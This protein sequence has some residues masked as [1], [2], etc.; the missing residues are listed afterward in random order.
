VSNPT[1]ISTGGVV[2]VSDQNT[3]IN[4]IVPVS[5]SWTLD[6]DTFY[7]YNS[8]SSPIPLTQGFSYF[9][10]NNF[11]QTS[12][13]PLTHLQ[14]THWTDGTWHIQDNSTDTSFPIKPYTLPV[15]SKVLGGVKS[16]GSN[17][18]IDPD[19]TINAVNGAQVQSDWNETN[20]ALPDFILN[21]PTFLQVQSDWNETNPALPDF[22]LNKPSIPSPYVLPAATPTV[23]GGI[24]VGSGLVITGDVL[25]APGG[26][27]GI[28][29]LTGDGTAGPGTGSQP[30][31]LASVVAPGTVGDTT[32]VAQVTIDG[33]GRVTA[34]TPIAIAGVSPTCMPKASEVGV[35]ANG[36]DQTANLIAALS[37]PNY[38]GIVFDFSPAS[39]VVINGSVNCN[40]K[41]LRFQPGNIITG[42]FTI[43]NF[44]LDCNIRQKCF[45]IGSSGVPVGITNPIGTTLGYISPWVFGA[46]D[47]GSDISRAW[48]ATIDLCIRNGNKVCHIK[49]P[50]GTYTS[51][52]PVIE[53]LW[54]GSFYA[55]HQVITDGETNFSEASSFGTVINFTR[56]DCFCHATQAS[57]GGSLKNIK[58]TGPFTNP[59][60][61]SSYAFYNTTS[62][63]YTDGVT[64]DTQFSPQAINVIDPF[65]PSIPADGGYPG[66]D[67]YGQPL[68]EYYRGST[69]GT[70]GYEYENVFRSGCVVGLVTSPNGQTA[71]AEL[72]SDRNA[73]FQNYKWMV[74]GCQTQEKGNLV[75][76]FQ[77]W[78]QGYGIFANNVYGSQAAGGWTF[79]DGNIA[80]PNVLFGSYNDSGFI[81]SFFQNIFIELLGSMGSMKTDQGASFTDCTFNFAPYQS[82]QS[83]TNCHVNCPGFTFVGGEMKMYGTFKP[84]TIDGTIGATF[85]QGV[86]FET[87]PFFTTGY[88]RGNC[89]F[90]NCTVGGDIMNPDDL[91]TVLSSGFSDTFAYGNVKI[92]AGARTYKIASSYPAM[93]LPFQRTISA[94]TITITVVSG[95]RR[96]AISAVSDEL[97]RVFVGDPIFASTSPTGVQRPFGIVT[98]VGGGIATIDYLPAWLV[99]GNSYYLFVWLP[100]YNI[101]FIGDTT[102]GGN[103]ITN[104]TVKDGSLTPIVTL[105]GLIFCKAFSQ[106][107]SWG[108]NLFRARNWNPGTATLL[109][110]RNA[111]ISTT[112]LW[113]INSN[114]TVVPVQSEIAGTGVVNLS[115]GTIGIPIDGLT[116]NS[117]A[118]VSLNTY[119][120]A[121]LTRFYSWVCTPGLLTI[122]ALQS[123]GS[124]N[125]ADGS[126]VSYTVYY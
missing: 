77:A 50:A 82:T 66:T 39:P 72:I 11:L 55:P 73:Q 75:D 112:V 120:G 125:A 3:I 46:K 98:S 79:R 14:I 25:S 60:Y 37:N 6:F 5:L 45:D 81:P 93:S 100:L 117:K 32:H 74:G 107:D 121:S 114:A 16:G 33:K 95:V 7:I 64:R 80:G 102:S 90:K 123:T 9:D 36:L 24:K 58:I 85:F 12:I 113:F 110:D 116:A 101:S 91:Q 17:I 67:A 108:Y 104:V 69:N 38:S 34:L 51:N 61:A 2:V 126:A 29:Q 106:T 52:E 47:D 86:S 63:A 4:G 13:P 35:L 62:G 30:F 65:G 76:F 41:T 15:A 122:S 48:Q 1:T 87:V 84:V 94:Y 42:T 99:S 44:I 109:L 56:H 27:G 18:V 8:T 10:D 31:T 119:S 22:I 124:L 54:N 20:P 57:K 105:G 111:A 96:S 83:Y 71:N 88:F 19:G 103:S 115:S 89:S 26:S 43:V 49:F 40:G 23:R 70:T 78:G 28:T 92:N 118:Q 53:Y 59:T 97:N 21:K 68:S